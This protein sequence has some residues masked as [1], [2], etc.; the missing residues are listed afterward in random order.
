MQ[1]PSSRSLAVPIAPKT[2]VSPSTTAPATTPSVATQF[3]VA[4][5]TTDRLPATH[6]ERPRLPRKAAGHHEA[7]PA[8][9]TEAWCRRAEVA[10]ADD[11]LRNAYDE[12]A[13]AGIDRD[14]LVAVRNDWARLRRRANR[15]PAAL[16]RGYRELTGQLYA[17]RRGPGR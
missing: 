17:E 8:S 2:T 9:A 7:C 5:S 10:A 1:P 14:V 12:A 15:D 16:I 11:R 4:R 6:I 3:T 13:R